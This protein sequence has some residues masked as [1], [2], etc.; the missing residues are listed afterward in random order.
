MSININTQNPLD[1]PEA[2]LGQL[3]KS[4]PYA[5]LAY[6]YTPKDQKKDRPIPG[7]DYHYSDSEKYRSRDRKADRKANHSWC[8]EFFFGQQE[9]T[10]PHRLL[11]T[12]RSK[13]FKGENTMR[14][15]KIFVVF[16]IFMLIP[17]FVYAQASHQRY[18]Q[19]EK[20]EHAKMNLIKNGTFKSGLL[21]P[22]E[23]V[24][25]N[26]KE[27]NVYEAQIFSD[28]FMWSRK[29]SEGDGGYIGIKQSL[30]NYKLR[31]NKQV[32]LSF[33][34]LISLQELNSDGW[35]GGEYPAS[36]ILTFV[37]EHGEQYV[38]KKCFLLKGSTINYPEN[39]V[40]EIEGGN[41]YHFEVDLMEDP[42]ISKNILAHPYLKEIRAG[43][44]GWDFVG[45]I[46]NI[47]LI[48]E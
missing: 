42:E 7:S 22:W 24:L 39:N 20:E 37:N 15:R 3:G 17:C 10:G 35:A 28:Y 30:G 12:I 11:R 18:D 48:V 14:Y 33:D 43:G 31:G 46:D 36:V 5:L 26:I 13:S 47:K 21:S 4:I 45:A 34:V 32:V 25:I 41:F 16:L 27:S 2:V 19:T 44:S 9:I 40:T 38:Y 8:M 23:I 1:L 29:N 6:T